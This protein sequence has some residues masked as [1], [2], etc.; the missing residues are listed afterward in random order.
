VSGSTI[1]F[2]FATFIEE[3]FRIDFTG[4]VTGNRMGGT[5]AVVF[6]DP[7]ESPEYGTWSMMRQ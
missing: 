5:L 6:E 2:S 3:A 4:T 1:A 7:T